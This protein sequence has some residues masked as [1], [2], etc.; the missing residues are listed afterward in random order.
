M[1]F[2]NRFLNSVTIKAID[3]SIK[4]FNHTIIDGT[5]KN[6]NVCSMDIVIRNMLF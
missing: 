5:D 3:K 1:F 4:T 6:E 2:K